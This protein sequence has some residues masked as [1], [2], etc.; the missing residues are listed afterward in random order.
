[1][2][3]LPVAPPDAPDVDLGAPEEVTPVATVTS[4]QRR[5]EETLREDDGVLTQVSQP[6]YLGGKRT[7]LPLG[8]DIAEHA[9]ARWRIRADDPLS[10]EVHN[11]CGVTLKRGDWSV[12][13]E[14][15]ATLR[16]TADRFIATSIVRAFEGEAHVHE[17]IFE[18]SAPR[19]G[20]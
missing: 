14:T 7:I 15:E 18:T 12:R 20:G 4:D 5:G 19:A 8:I 3:R 17:R 2:L 1:V 9:R 13:I 6:D 10:A 16:C 11:V